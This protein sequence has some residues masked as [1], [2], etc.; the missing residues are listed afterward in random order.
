MG[1]KYLAKKAVAGGQR[2]DSRKE[3]KRYLE[4]RALERMGAIS[5]LETQ[6]AFELIPAQRE[7]PTITRAGK[8]R[9]G[10]TIERAVTYIADFCYR[11]KEGNLVVEDVKG[12]RRGTAYAV[13]SIKRKLMLS[14][15]GIRVKEI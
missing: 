5:E 3:A 10:R 11:D 14:V 8:E 2:F 12:Y 1:S 4:L 6:R 7:A 13:F 15:Y 9:P